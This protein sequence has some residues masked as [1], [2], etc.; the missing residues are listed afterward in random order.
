[1]SYLAVTLMK[2]TTP[3]ETLMILIKWFEEN[4]LKELFMPGFPGLKKDFYVLLSL[5]E[6]YMPEIYAKFSEV[7]YI[8]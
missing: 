4:G 3:E 8:P 7:N 1:M 5:Q 6:K 2:Y